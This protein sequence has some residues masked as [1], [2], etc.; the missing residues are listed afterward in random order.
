LHPATLRMRHSSTA[1]PQKC[2]VGEVTATNEGARAR[3]RETKSCCHR[4]YRYSCFGFFASFFLWQQ[5]QLPRSAGLGGISL[6]II[7]VH[8][9]SIIIM[10]VKKKKMIMLMLMR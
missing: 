4:H 9:R 8:V 6:Y 1:R 7:L 3:G 5:Q 10:H 2:P